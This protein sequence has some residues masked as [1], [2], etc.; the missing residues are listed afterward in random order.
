MCAGLFV[1]LV[2]AERE[3]QDPSGEM[4]DF[5]LLARNSSRNVD[6]NP[7]ASGWTVA[8]SA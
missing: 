2:G 6:G 7:T 1:R 3:D 4:S 5:S 8:G